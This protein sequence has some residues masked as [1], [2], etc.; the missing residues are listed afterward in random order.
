MGEGGRVETGEL[1]EEGEALLPVDKAERKR[2]RTSP[3]LS[4]RWKTRGNMI[5]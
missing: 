5:S 4:E 2:E 1:H 3:T